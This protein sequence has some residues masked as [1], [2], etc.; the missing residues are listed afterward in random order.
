[1]RAEFRAA[2]GDLPGSL[3]DCERYLALRPDDA[4]V[5]FVQAVALER[6]GRRGDAAAAYR[7]AA[8]L[9]PKAFEP[10]NNLAELL[11]ADGD[12]DGALEAAQAA[13]ALAERNPYVMDTL[14]GLYLRK[15]LVDRHAG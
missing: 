12:L 14:G 10:R 9:D 1:V 15:G 5:R 8:E 4:R 2:R 13:Y 11:A 6:S 7:R 3:A